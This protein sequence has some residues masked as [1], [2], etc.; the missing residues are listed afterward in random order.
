LLKIVRADDATSDVFFTASTQEETSIFHNGFGGPYRQSWASMG[1]IRALVSRGLLEITEHKSG[2]DFAFVVTS[3][4]RAQ[5]EALRRIGPSPLQLAVGRAEQAEARMRELEEGAKTDAAA[6]KG[7]RTRNA[8]RLAWLPALVVA[9]AISAGIFW[10]FQLNAT[11]ALA[12]TALS[13]FGV[14]GSWLVRP[15]RDVC[16]RWLVRV[17]GFIHEQT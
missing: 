11:T 13:A 6:E 12:A 3:A 5:A 2:G 7:R 14:C 16:A 1:D 17:F 10:L 15:V 9:L 4:G 8:R